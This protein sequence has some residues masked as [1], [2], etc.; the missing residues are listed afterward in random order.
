ML[1]DRQHDHDDQR[2]HRTIQTNR[3]AIAAKTIKFSVNW[4]S[5]RISGAH[6]EWPRAVHPSSRCSSKRLDKMVHCRGRVNWFDDVKRRIRQPPHIPQQRPL[7]VHHRAIVLHDHH[8]QP[9]QPP[10][11]HHKLSCDAMPFRPTTITANPARQASAIHDASINN[12]HNHCHAINAT[13]TNWI[14]QMKVST[15][16]YEL[17]AIVS[18]VGYAID[19]RVPQIIPHPKIGAA[20]RM[21]T[22]RCIC[23]PNRQHR[24]IIDRRDLRTMYSQDRQVPFPYRQRVARAH[25]NDHIIMRIAMKMRRIIE[26]SVVRHK[27]HH[28][29]GKRRK[30]IHFIGFFGG[31]VFSWLFWAA[32]GIG[33]GGSMWVGS[34]SKLQISSIFR[35]DN[36]AI[37]IRRLSFFTIILLCFCG[38]VC[39]W[40]C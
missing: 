16:R 38:I 22:H 26:R 18:R 35:I 12:S 5:Q 14:S 6:V 20:N 17:P 34:P 31:I 1:V 23:W 25:K 7:P 40:R 2:D 21:T 33:F 19:H 11:V 8:H 3:M 28:L 9:P 4:H 29:A 24:V 27:V 10:K 39:L 30:I 15:I 36:S 37:I 32:F 13:P